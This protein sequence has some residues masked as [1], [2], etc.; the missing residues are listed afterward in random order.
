MLT[1]GALGSDTEHP[2]Q[3]RQVMQSQEG[4][5]NAVPRPRFKI[6]DGMGD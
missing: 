5:F 1:A 2:V 4:P 6:N 3:V